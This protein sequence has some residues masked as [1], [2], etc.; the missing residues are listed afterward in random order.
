MKKIA[1]NFPCKIKGKIKKK[2]KIENYTYTYPTCV[3]DLKH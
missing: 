1:K 2:I 3:D